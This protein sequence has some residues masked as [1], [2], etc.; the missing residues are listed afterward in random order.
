VPVVAFDCP[1]GPRDII[2]NEV[3]GLLLNNGDVEALTAALQ[4]VL[5]ESEFA[6]SLRSAAAQDARLYDLPTISKAYL[7]LFNATLSRASSGS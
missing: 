3:N 1:Y 5:S 7:D 4:R 6:K 2:H